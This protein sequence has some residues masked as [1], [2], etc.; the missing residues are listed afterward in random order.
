[1]IKVGYLAKHRADDDVGIV[2]GILWNKG[3]PMYQIKWG[4]GSTMEHRY[5]EFE[6]IH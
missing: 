1:M 5:G 4:D 6:I 2:I 3:V